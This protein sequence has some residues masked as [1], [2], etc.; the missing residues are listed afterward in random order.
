M[1]KMNT[2]ANKSSEVLSHT[3]K[4][5]Y[6]CKSRKKKFRWLLTCRTRDS[7]SFSRRASLSWY[8]SPL[9]DI[10]PLVWKRQQILCRQLS[11]HK[12]HSTL[13]THLRTIFRLHCSRTDLKYSSAPKGLEIKQTVN[14]GYMTIIQDKN[15]Q[16]LK[17]E[18]GR[19]FWWPNSAKFTYCAFSILLTKFVLNDVLC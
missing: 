16:R 2:T 8:T 12:H 19:T 11:Y 6:E 1:S 13:S 17:D 9:P 4:K 18:K 15:F 14:K 3:I 10:C 5:S 7:L